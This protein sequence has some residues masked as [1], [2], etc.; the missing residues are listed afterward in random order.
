MAGDR[1]WCGPLVFENRDH[2]CISSS[3]DPCSALASEKRSSGFAALQGLNIATRY[4]WKPIFT[5]EELNHLEKRHEVIHATKKRKEHDMEPPLPGSEPNEL[6]ASSSPA[7][8]PVQERDAQPPVERKL[9]FFKRFLKILGP[10]LITGAS[11]DDPSGIGT[12]S[13][14]GASLG[15]ATLWM[16]LITFP[17][18]AS[19]QFICAKVGLVSGMGLAGV[20]RKHY[21]RWLLYPVV[22]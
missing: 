3:V 14:A 2:V 20:L 8:A 22:V 16:A 4:L 6:S 5:H 15:Y 9:S 19:A 13:M 12:Y 10:G 18:M 1:S 17:L 21:P 7:Q 11:D